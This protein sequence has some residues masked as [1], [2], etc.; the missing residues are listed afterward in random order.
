[1]AKQAYVYSGTD[2][3]PLAS[4]VTN[5]SNYQLS[6]GTGLNAIIP[7]S[8]TVGSGSASIGTAGQVTFTGASSVSLNGVFTSAYRNYRVLIE[9]SGAS[10][11][12]AYTARFRTAGSD[13]TSG[14]YQVQELYGSGST[15]GA[16]RAAN[17]TNWN[18]SNVYTEKTCMIL[19]ILSPQVATSTSVFSTCLSN[20]TS[21]TPEITFKTI[22]FNA[23][24]Q[25]DGISWIS[26]GANMTGTISVY[27]YK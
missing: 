27:G 17:G 1:M 5:L 11:S 20:S 15:T 26:S 2:W 4:E 3:V 19:D 25:F 7:T 24:N 23:T 8:V 14:N 22:G 18:N 10:A 13:V 21:T 12:G 6:S 9:S 16:G